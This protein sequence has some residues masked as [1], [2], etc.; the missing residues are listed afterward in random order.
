VPWKVSVGLELAS[1]NVIELVNA[2]L[3]LLATERL[4]GTM[5]GEYRATEYV[6][7]DPVLSTR[8]ST[9]LPFEG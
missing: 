2:T 3:W 4:K 6:P 7:A 5:P 9:W 1:A 8:P